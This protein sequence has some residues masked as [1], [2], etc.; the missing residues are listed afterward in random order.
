MVNGLGQ[1]SYSKTKI[2]LQDKS[3]R[4]GEESGGKDSQTKATEQNQTEFMERQKLH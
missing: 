2:M 4:E 1:S 3:K